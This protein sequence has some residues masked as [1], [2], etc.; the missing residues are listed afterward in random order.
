MG[1]PVQHEVGAALIDRPAEQVAAEER[2]DLGS[3]AHHGVL[4]R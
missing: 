3:L 2:E 4:H 1:V